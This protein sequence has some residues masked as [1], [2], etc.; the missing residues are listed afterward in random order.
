MDGTGTVGDRRWVQGKQGRIERRRRRRRRT[1]WRSKRSSD[2]R[3]PGIEFLGAGS[4]SLPLQFPLMCRAATRPWDSAW[5]T[6]A[7]T[8]AE[9]RR[10]VYRRTERL[11]RRRRVG[12]AGGE[13]GGLPTGASALDGWVSGRERGGGVRGG[14]E[15]GKE[16]GQEEGPHG[17]TLLPGSVGRGVRGHHARGSGASQASQARQGSYLHGR[18]GCDCADTA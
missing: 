18:P 4:V 11:R 13:E 10:Y 9:W 8:P 15:K 1:E 6:L 3:A 14:V 5:S 7:S 12:G 2:P 17:V 16:V